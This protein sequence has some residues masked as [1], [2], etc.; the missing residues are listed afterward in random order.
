[1]NDISSLTAMPFL[2]GL[3]LSLGVAVLG[4]R[5]GFDRD[6]AFYATIV[7]V[8]ASYY[9]LFAVLGGSTTALITET[10]VMGLFVAAAVVGFRSSPWLIAGALAAHGAFDAVHG[11]LV[12][13]P[14]VPAWWPAF[15]GTY[16]VAA[17]VWLAWLLRRDERRGR[18]GAPATAA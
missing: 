3:A 8:V 6:R 12:T 2:I 18:R 1:M 17:A 10:A 5:A 13:N 11:Q 16:D 4:R 7:M 15:C 9:V 14:G